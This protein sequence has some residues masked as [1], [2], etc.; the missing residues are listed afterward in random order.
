MNE[1]DRLACN[2]RRQNPQI[3][4]IIINCDVCRYRFKCY[5]QIDF[6]KEF[7][8]FKCERGHWQVQT[9]PDCDNCSKNIRVAF[10]KINFNGE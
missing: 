3:P 8:C 9:I 6:E 10:K 5:T 7:S 4:K 2:H 1:A